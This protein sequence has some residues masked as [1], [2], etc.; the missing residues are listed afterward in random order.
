MNKTEI[1]TKYE[2]FI[3]DHFEIQEEPTKLKIIYFFEI[4]GLSKFTP[5]IE[6][7]KKENKNIT[8][9]VEE[10][11]F[12]LG[13]IE[14]ISYWKCCCPKN[15]QIH[16][17]HLRE[18][19]KAWFQKIYMYGLGEFFYTN[20]IE[21][22]DSILPNIITTGPKR[23]V[24]KAYDG[25]GAMIAI[26][27]GK[28]SCVSL[29]LLKNDQNKKAFIINPKPVMLECAKIAGIKEENILKV[30][31]EIDPNLIE[32]NKQGYLNGHT[33]FSAMVAFTSFLTAYLNDIQDIV[34]SNEASAN[35]S[36]IKGTKINHQYSKTFEFEQDFTEYTSKYL[37]VNMKYFSLLRPLNEYQIGMLFSKEP[38]FHPIFKS[39]N[40]G[41]KKNPWE[42]C[43]SCSKCLFV[44]SMLSPFLY[45]EQLIYIFSKDLF[46][47]KEL[48]ETFL[49]LLGYGKNKP[50][51]CV[52]TYEEIN[53][54]IQKTIQK[55]NGQP[56]PY[57]LEYYN[58]NYA[59]NLL[60]KELEKNWNS[61]HNLNSDYE[62]IVKEAIFHDR[63]NS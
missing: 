39:C 42:W 15:I 4:P 44:F 52:G 24:D 7:P 2:N 27:G 9:T 51:D 55:L 50:F 10:L 60:E 48:L 56:L 61:D 21:M 28:D 59:L 16:C 30:K 38:K 5:Q 13:L 62:K 43:A 36:N 54:A 11:V 41:S 6:I 20:E 57:L 8:E 12:Q 22:N 19:Q 63:T 26:G 18:E 32:L 53:Y 40:V 25:K 23:T 14:L 17:G 45:K 33:P 34:L 46:E 58:Q 31:R 49:D 1:L 35:E 37:K 47:D 3:Y 29:N